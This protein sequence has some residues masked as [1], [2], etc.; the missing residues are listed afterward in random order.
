MRSAD[1]VEDRIDPGGELCAVLA[2][3]KSP[4]RSS[5]AFAPKL[6]TTGMLAAEDVPM[7]FR[8]KWRARSSKAVP[9][10]PEAP[11]ARIVAP[12]GELHG[13]G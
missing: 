5:M 3:T 11:I 6:S 8:P 9:T 12:T 10:V 13:S 4:S 7:A 1:G 2:A